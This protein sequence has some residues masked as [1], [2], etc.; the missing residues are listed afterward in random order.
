MAWS[1]NIEPEAFI[2]GQKL[3]C[4]IMYKV[5]FHNRKRSTM[6][7]FDDKSWRDSR[8]F[9]CDLSS[10]LSFFHRSI[11]PY[12]FQRQPCPSALLSAVRRGDRNV[13]ILCGH[14]IKA[15]HSGEIRGKNHRLHRKKDWNFVDGPDVELVHRASLTN[16]EE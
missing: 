13:G 9:I 16:P 10:K 8:F 5:S 12:L 3:A 14:S 7:C 2:V 1:G 11:Y 4:D 15:M 6:P